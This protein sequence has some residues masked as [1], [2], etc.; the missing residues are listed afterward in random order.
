MLTKA[1]NPELSDH[2]HEPLGPEQVMCFEGQNI[3]KP[4]L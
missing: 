2:K 4:K 1:I 3:K